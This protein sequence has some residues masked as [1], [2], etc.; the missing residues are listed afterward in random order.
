[1]NTPTRR[2]DELDEAEKDL[3][4]LWRELGSEL[5][6]GSSPDSSGADETLEAY[7][8]WRRLVASVLREVSERRGALIA[9]RAKVDDP[10]MLF[11]LD[12]HIEAAEVALA[13]LGIIAAE[14]AP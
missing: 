12:V 13:A 10:D 1:M 6:G 4:W 11:A 9:A 14:G 5:S 2:V 3:A 7:E 8:G